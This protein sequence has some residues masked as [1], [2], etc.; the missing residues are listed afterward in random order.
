[1]G[2]FSPLLPIDH[3]SVIAAIRIAEV[4]TSGA[5]HVM[6]VHHKVDDPVVEAQAYFT[7]HGMDKSAQRNAVLIFIA[8]VS[9]KFAVIGDS[10]VHEKCGDTFWTDLTAAMSV[11]F[12]QGE[13]TD[14]LV[15][16]VETAGD[17]L[18][19]HFPRRAKDA[20]PAPPSVTDV[21]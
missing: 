15:H 12:K 6:V 7:K 5:L 19:A 20:P 13:F 14:G 18:A 11:Y 1:M 8:P 2:L 17:L 9:R 21:D 4:K 10:G 16:G 3:E